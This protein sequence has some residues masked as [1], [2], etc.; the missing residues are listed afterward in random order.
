MW[1]SSSHCLS[2]ENDGTLRSLA[3]WMH[4]TIELISRRN[5]DMHMHLHDTCLRIMWKDSS[6]VWAIFL[7][8]FLSRFREE[9][10][11]SNSTGNET[12]DK[13]IPASFLVPDL[14]APTYCV[15]SLL[16]QVI[17]VG[18]APAGLS[19]LP[20]VPPDRVHN[21][22]PTHHHGCNT[23]IIHLRD[24]VGLVTPPSSPHISAYSSKCKSLGNP[25]RKLMP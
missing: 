25:V 12:R 9:A 4:S 3:A 14:M 10:S 17:N 5:L 8:L 22:A 24:G 15:L 19:D 7:S 13:F 23:V 2:N 18:S 21:D 20:V 6:K 1:I 16:T 11:I